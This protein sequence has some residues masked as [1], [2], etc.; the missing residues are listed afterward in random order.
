MLAV[1]G[2]S[3]Q[4]NEL[5]PVK[6]GNLLHLPAASTVAAGVENL[7]PEPRGFTDSNLSLAYRTPQLNTL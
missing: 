1:T 6:K 7:Y 4:V 5:P 3:R 2:M